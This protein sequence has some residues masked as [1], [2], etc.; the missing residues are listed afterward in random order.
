M[1]RPGQEPHWLLKDAGLRLTIDRPASAADA[2][3]A[4]GAHDEVVLARLAL[5]PLKVS[6]AYSESEFM[7]ELL[8]ETIAIIT[9]SAPVDA[10]P[11]GPSAGGGG[12]GADGAARADGT[13]PPL[14]TAQST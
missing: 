5:S 3:G 13:S 7:Y 12:G 1:L 8:T 6:L 2:H 10:S 14:M 9:P 4:H 11:D